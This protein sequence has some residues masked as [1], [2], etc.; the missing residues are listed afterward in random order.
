MS[1]R[2]RT[3]RDGQVISDEPYT[4]ASDYPRARIAA[5]LCPGCP[6]GRGIT[7]GWNGTTELL[8]CDRCTHTWFRGHPSRQETLFDIEKD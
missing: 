7:T 8:K 4:P 6:T 5:S 1:Q 3:T 2:A